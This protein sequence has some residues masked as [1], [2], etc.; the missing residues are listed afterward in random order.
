MHVG[1]VH[2]DVVPDERGGV[3][4]GVWQCV[5]A[6]ALSTTSA[7]AVRRLVQ[8]LDQFALELRLADPDVEPE[9]AAG[10]DEVLGEFGA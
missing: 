9:P 8:P 1:D 3:G 5:Q 4:D 2:L 7:P 10:L 6:P